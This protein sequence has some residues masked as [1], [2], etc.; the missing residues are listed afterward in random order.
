MHALTCSYIKLMV[1]T[2]SRQVHSALMPSSLL[3]ESVLH[4]DITG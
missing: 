3:F 4:H 1:T 2:A